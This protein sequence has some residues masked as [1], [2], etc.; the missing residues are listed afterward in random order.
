MK[1]NTFTHTI[2]IKLILNNNIH[3]T[4]ITNVCSSVVYWLHLLGYFYWVYS[5]DSGYK[6][7][8]YVIKCICVFKI[9]V[10]MYYKLC[11]YILYLIT[12][13]DECRIFSLFIVRFLLK[14]VFLIKCA[15]NLPHARRVNWLLATSGL[16]IIVWQHIRKM[17]GEPDVT[18]LNM[19]SEDYAGIIKSIMKV[20]HNYIYHYD[21]SFAKF[22]STL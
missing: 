20:C 14:I 21:S 8:K 15:T 19:R 17:C 11:L 4:S 9:I 13:K 22:N 1:Y 16:D 6:L 12:L 3:L 10:L 2:I 7:F 18:S 5:N